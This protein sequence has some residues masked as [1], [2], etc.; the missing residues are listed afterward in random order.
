MAVEKYKRKTDKTIYD[1]F[2]NM[3]KDHS[4]NL[5]LKE[6]ISGMEKLEVR[7]S[8]EELEFLFYSIDINRDGSIRYIEFIDAI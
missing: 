6:F 1:I 7:L 8:I 4:L 2:E 3:D 5:D